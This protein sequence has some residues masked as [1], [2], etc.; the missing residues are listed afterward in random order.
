M[1]SASVEH[2]FILSFTFILK[3]AQNFS[4]GFMSGEYGGKNSTSHPALLIISMLVFD[5]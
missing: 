1:A 5:L 4:I 3:L 2:S